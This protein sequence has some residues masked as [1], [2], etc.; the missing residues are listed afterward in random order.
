MEI[1][2]PF[3]PMEKEHVVYNTTENSFYTSCSPKI[4]EVSG[5]GLTI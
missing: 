4:L 3:I 1:R 2:E 5:E